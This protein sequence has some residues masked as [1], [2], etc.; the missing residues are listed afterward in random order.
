[1]D[2][3]AGSPGML[4]RATPRWGTHACTPCISEAP[5]DWA[6]PPASIGAGSPRLTRGNRLLLGAAPSALLMHLGTRGRRRQDRSSRLRS[7]RRQGK[8]KPAVGTLFS[9]LMGEKKKGPLLT[10]H[11]D[12][13][14][15]IGDFKK[16][17]R[18][19]GARFDGVDIRKT[20]DGV[21]L[22]VFATRS[23]REDEVILEVPRRLCIETPFPGVMNLPEDERVLARAASGKEADAMSHRDA[24][25]SMVA[26]SRALLHERK[27]EANSD[28]APY[29]DLLPDPPRLHSLSTK[30]PRS[31]AEVS[32]VL[33]R[34]HD[35]ITQRDLQCLDLLSEESDWQK[36]CWALSAVNTRAFDLSALGDKRCLSMVPLVDL[37]NHWTP[38]HPQDEGW[39]TFYE[40]R[41]DA[42]AIVAARPIGRGEELTILYDEKSDAE[43]LCQYGIAP[44][45]TGMNQFNKAGFQVPPSA[46]CLQP[47]GSGGVPDPLLISAR[48]GVLERHGWEDLKA[49]LLFSVPHDMRPR[50]GLLAL[51]RLLSLDTAE[52]V[53]EQE[54]RIFWMDTAESPRLLSEDMN[55]V[56]ERRAWRLLASWLSDALAEDTEKAAVFMDGLSEWADSAP[57]LANAVGAVV[58]GEIQTLEE[59]AEKAESRSRRVQWKGKVQRHMH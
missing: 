37:V 46:L 16:W 23:F 33:A 26:L 15:R 24:L 31:L 44:P 14:S 8:K 52:E 25:D 45:M 18:A 28:F 58:V 30:W 27:S 34:M 36:R 12:P 47:D 17:L 42:V 43:L 11:R 5:R 40:E 10:E 6:P 41:G 3:L 13:A 56:H 53:V 21:E 1:M 7:V 59:S 50:G 20:W 39:S 22:G 19:G 32:P 29:I 48:A 4:A 9:E 54:P 57:F 49:P 55:P 35:T 38:M 2:A 51:A